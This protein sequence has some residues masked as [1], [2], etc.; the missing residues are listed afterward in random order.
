MKFKQKIKK[1]G[2]L[3]FLLFIIIS[4]V[5]KIPIRAEID[6]DT[7]EIKQKDVYLQDLI[8]N[9]PSIND[10]GEINDDIISQLQTIDTILS[11]LSEEELLSYDLTTYNELK[12][13]VDT[14]SERTNK[15]IVYEELNNVS[16]TSNGS[17]TV[18]DSGYCGYYGMWGGTT[19]TVYSD[20]SMVISASSS[21]SDDGIYYD[22]WSEWNHI[23]PTYYKLINKVIIEDGVTYIGDGV[24][25]GYEKLET[26]EMPNSITSIGERAFS[27][28]VEL[29]D[30]V[31]SENLTEIK[32]MAFWNCKKI[33]NIFIPRKVSYIGDADCAFRNMINLETIVVDENNPYFYSE[34]NCVIRK[35]DKLLFI[36]TNKT[37]TVPNGVKTIKM[38][39]FEDRK[40]IDTVIIP[41][42]VEVVSQFSFFNCSSLSRI[43]VPKTV[44][45]IYDVGFHGPLTSKTY[46]KIYTDATSK[47]DEWHST[48]Y[49]N[50][51]Y[52]VV[53]GSNLETFKD[54]CL[55][56]SITFDGNGSSSGSTSSMSN[57]SCGVDYY[58][59]TN[60]FVKDGYIFDGWNTKQDGSG[61][62]FTDGQKIRNLSVD[63]GRN[64]TLYAQWT[65][66]NASNYTVNHYFQNLEGDGYTKDANKTQVLEDAA[67]KSVKGSHIQVVGFEPDIRSSDTQII[68]DDDST[69]INLYYK[70]VVKTVTFDPNGGTMDQTSFVG[71]YGKQFD[72][73]ES[74]TKQGYVFNGWNPELTEN[75]FTIP[76]ENKTYTATWTEGTSNYNVEYY[77]QDTD[78][79]NYTKDNSLS[80][81]KQATTS[82]IVTE[83]PQDITGFTYNSTKSNK[84]GTV[85]AD[86]SLVLKLYYDRNKYTVTYN[87]NGGINND[88]N[89][90]Y[91][92]YGV[93]VSSFKPATKSGF[94]FDGWHSN[95]GTGDN[96]GN[97]IENISNVSTGNITLY[98]KW[99]FKYDTPSP[100]A[101][102][103]GEV[104]K[105]TLVTLDCS[106][107]LASIYYTT[108]GSDPT[109][110]ST[111]FE[112]QIVI[113]EDTT[114]K[115]IAINENKN[116]SEVV[117]FIYTIKEET[118][119]DI[120]EEDK[121]QYVSEGF[122][123]N[124]LEDFTYD[125]SIKK[126][127][128]DE[129]T[130]RVYDHKT[131]LTLNKDYTV[132]YKNNTKAG[133]A[134]LT[135]TGKGNY[136]ST[137]TKTFEI[138]K[139]GF[140]N[141]NIV[142]NLNKKLFTY[143]GK[144]QKPSI[145][146]VEYKCSTDGKVYK[147]KNNVDYVATIPSSSIDP[148][149]DYKVTI[150]G[151]GNYQ[152]MIQT[153]Y[154]ITNNT[155]ASTFSISGLKSSYPY[156]NGEEIKPDELGT[157]VVKS[158]K[159]ILEK[160]THYTI[161]YGANVSV[162][163]AKLIIIGNDQNG[164]EGTLTKTFK[165]T[166]TAL[167]SY[168][169][170]NMPSS[171]V[172]KGYDITVANELSSV[173][174]SKTANGVTTTLTGKA[175][176]QY[177]S[178]L[179]TDVDYV[180]SYQNNKNIGTATVIFEGVNGFT[181]TV[182]KTFKITG[183]ALSKYNKVD[184]ETK[185]YTGEEIT[186]DDKKLYY[187]DKVEG[188]KELE[189]DNNYTITYQKNINAGTATVIYTG[190]NGY[191][192][193]IKKTFKI[194]KQSIADDMFDDLDS[195][196]FI[197]GGVKPTIS[198]SLILNTDYTVKYTNN[199][200]VN[201]NT[202]PKKITKVT[203]TGKGNYQGTITKEFTIDQRNL[204][205]NITITVPDKVYSNKANVYKSAPTLIDTDGKKLVAG[206]DY[207]KNI[208]YTYKYDTLVTDTSVKPNVL[209]VREE[210][211][212]VGPKDIVPV[213]T[214]IEVKVT[215][216]KNYKEEL[217][218]TYRIIANDISKASVTI[219][220]QYY[221]GKPIVLFKSDITVK[222][223]SKVLSTRDFEIV[224]YTDNI[225]K[226][227]ASITIKGKGDFG[228]IKTV[229]FNIQS[230]TLR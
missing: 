132:S 110:Q 149:N 135:I 11:T 127:V 10:R 81:T 30:V 113:T 174:F 46:N 215:G 111:L 188:R 138:K 16:N 141:G 108:D 86:G 71:R 15:N 219:P 176:D 136:T 195:Y 74:P 166:G 229:K 211:S 144:A 194:N 98:A 7:Q 55:S 124:K 73:P 197:K 64:I 53:W 32:D 18:L 151:K 36:A 182:K 100:T 228:G 207:D 85:L 59:N 220:T 24:F 35:S 54:N 217:S 31:L 3:T 224:S 200:A 213:N 69:V 193:T 112:N 214:I 186:Q 39:A 21:F 196:S 203:I 172:Y 97:K 90:N 27:G 99:K 88:D 70:R 114:I 68:Q 133:E 202:N 42:S 162:G 226:G 181:G 190:I 12:S 178:Y 101:D 6:E 119:G 4:T 125:P 51:S 205:D 91:Y 80:L 40:E 115:A 38:Y 123:T 131:L 165:I 22:G 84:K 58:L 225:F 184:L 179:D 173:V 155:L 145:T 63:H 157:I 158:G 140:T 25:S 47:C 49:P 105:N 62:Q 160:G 156:N 1:I 41:E 137:L 129:S 8:D 218:A 212:E 227:S 206:S 107:S 75:T 96:W 50:D 61:T 223:G 216:I 154:T 153:T 185:I 76:E 17:L 150:L 93:G 189:K 117:T 199:T 34:D 126:Y 130:L 204:S 163:T 52:T 65:L 164:Y 192:G 14:T 143:N 67:G 37:R 2:C 57:K 170:L 139:T 152:G 109:N 120:I 221:T 187:I 169:L 26:V 20:Y 148:R 9:L 60:G 134:T 122:W 142:I 33:K 78:I 161:A 45:T 121:G 222:I 167:S 230:R 13:F 103:Q 77:L 44:V 28:C 19:Y 43:Y 5:F 175:K 208:I 104:E 92:Y 146:S 147:L 94:K 87:T 23:S 159:N 168:K 177:V 210:G 29:N 171:V 66:L 95:D 89:F 56:Y 79:I 209:V 106:D 128:Y 116:N 118:D 83:T 102:I 82:S 183:N 48:W 198:S 191:S 201:D 180:I 72:V